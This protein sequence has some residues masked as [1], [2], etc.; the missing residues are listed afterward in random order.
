LRPSSW[1]R[2]L[3]MRDGTSPDR[4]ISK[5]ESPMDQVIRP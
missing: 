5:P 2:A 3:A 1:R 4:V